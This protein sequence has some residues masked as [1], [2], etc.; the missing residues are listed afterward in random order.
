MSA[1]A[2]ILGKL[3][4]SLAGTTPRPDDVNKEIRRA[5]WDLGREWRRSGQGGGGR[6]DDARRPATT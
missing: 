5:R 2:N 4:N 6:H 1:R 3:R